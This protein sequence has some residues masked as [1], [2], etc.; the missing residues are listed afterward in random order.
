[1]GKVHASI[2]DRLR[3]F[4]EAQPVFFV[5][6]APL[7]GRVNVSPKG[8]ADCFAVVDEH[9]VAY[10]DL[11]ASGAETIAHVRDNGRITVMFCSFDRTPN[12]VRLHGT[13][14][15]VSVHDADFER[16]AA[17]FPANPGARAV[18]VVDVE[19]VAD[20]CG[21]SLP[22]MHLEQERDL[23]TPT[24]ERRGPQGVV[25]YRRAKNRVSIDGL[26]A[27]DDDD[28]SAAEAPPVGDPVPGWTRRPPVVPVALHGRYVDLEPLAPSHADDLF[29]A[30][31]GDPLRWTYLFD[32]MPATR[33]AFQ[34]YV[35]Q[36][37]AH[38]DPA[39]VAIVPRGGRTAGVASWMRCDP[40]QGAVEVGSILFGEGLARTAAATEAMVLMARHAFEDLGYHRY[41]WKCDALNAPSRRAAARLGF[42][43][44]GLF[45]QAVV[46]KGRNRDTAWFS[47]TDV[48][49]AA[50][51]PAHDSWLDPDNFED[52]VTGRGQRT[53]LSHLTRDALRALR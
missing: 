36:R 38:R 7:V 53:S 40:Q 43:F 9:T 51:A 5:A 26:P 22:L 8:L 46:Y 20:S 11:T 44:E 16:W 6:T 41:E 18:V 49:W 15:V 27:F 1:M 2:G 25:D 31:C 39:S 17:L 4:I 12:V 42:T 33:S 45:R 10:L 29:A 52:P 50:L 47:I 21:Y 19:R 30:T 32:E 23:L 48:E 34:A 24:M 35:D 3:E 14:R 37:A 28:G 13:G